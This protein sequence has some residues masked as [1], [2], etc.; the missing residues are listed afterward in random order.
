MDKCANHPTAFTSIKCKR[1]HKF[2]CGDCQMMFAEGVFCSAA[3]A[4]EWREFQSRVL[5]RGPRKTRISIT[6]CLQTLVLSAVLVAVIIG[7][8]YFWL[9]TL[10]PVE[11]WN[12]LSNMFSL[13]F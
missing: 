13:M 1:C 4:K 8:L 12:K 5:T 7:V 2:I 11:M 10:S 6:G 3:C 9:G